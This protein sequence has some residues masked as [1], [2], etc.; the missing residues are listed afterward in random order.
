[1]KATKLLVV[2]VLSA[3]TSMAQVQAGRIVGTVT[4][5]NKAVVPNAQV[6]ITNKNLP[7]PDRAIM[8]ASL[9]P[10]EPHPTMPTFRPASIA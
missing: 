5:P 8:T 2:F 4:D 7:V 10:S 9:L 6:V 3:A 1:M